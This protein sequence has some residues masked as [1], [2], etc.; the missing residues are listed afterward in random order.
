MPVSFVGS[1]MTNDGSETRA[2][3]GAMF[4]KDYTLRLAQA[5]EEFG[6]DRM[7]IAYRSNWPDPAQVAAYLAAHTDHIGFL[8]AHRP[9][10]SYPTFAATTYA[11]FDHLTNGRLT[12]HFISGGFD[13]DQQREG[14]FLKKDERYART[15]EYMQIV[16]KAW[17]SHEPFDYEGEHYR[18]T[19]FVSDVFPAQQP[20]PALSFGGSSAAAYAV[21]GAEADIYGLWAES[22]AGTAEQ[23]A[24]V[25]AA[26]R[27]AGRTDMPRLHCAFRPILGATEE[28][29][30]EKAHGVVDLIHARKQ[31]LS[32]SQDIASW[33]LRQMAEKGE[34][35]DRA[36]WTGTVA[37]TGGGGPVAALVGTPET[38]A[39]AL[40]DYVD[41]G[42]EI[43]AAHGY[44]YLEDAVEFGREVIPIVREEVAKRDAERGTLA[45][46]G[47]EG[48]AAASG[49]G[50]VG[51]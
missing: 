39:A 9:N 12:L 50:A 14:D 42:V 11:T 41:L 47:T 23:I 17:T 44:D 28:Q 46:A 10:V 26:A 20:R 49:A 16:K 5:H 7:L 1:A 4:D 27:A 2:R 25:R 15:R 37:A 32:K 8:V 36:L 34:R 30:W 29:A 35:Y 3:S 31:G 40:L 48:R 13:D 18:F 6:W 22:L 21:G 19:D 43:I 45:D 24:S 38:V 33:R 51:A